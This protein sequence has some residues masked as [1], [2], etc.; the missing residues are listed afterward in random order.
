MAD[1]EAGLSEI[2]SGSDDD[3]DADDSVE[4]KPLQGEELLKS[5]EL[6]ED[7][8]GNDDAATKAK[9]KGADEKAD[10]AKGT[11]KG[12]VPAPE[13]AENDSKKPAKADDR[14]VPLK[15]LE[16]ERKKRQAEQKR[17]AELERKLAQL[18][19]RLSVFEKSNGNG[20]GKADETNPDDEFFAAGPSGFVE[21][22]LTAVEQRILQQVG[23]LRGQDRL[24][25]SREIVRSMHKDYD[26]TIATFREL[27]DGDPSLERQCLSAPNPAKW[28]YDYT[29][30]HQKLA[31]VGS[32]E[33]L[34]AQ[35]R[36]RVRQELEQEQRGN[37]ARA[38]AAKVSTSSAG[39]RSA[40]STAPVDVGEESL[41]DLL[42]D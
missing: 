30:L 6:R 29:K 40:G 25:M 12:A 31:N 35:I 8:P 13:S 3:S 21:K 33:D 32:L 36:E 4:T 14:H 18:E 41:E 26:E 11:K 24:A 27:A 20:Q 10:E 28:A 15:A 16:E 42:K 19:G 37:S 22:K 7:D 5:E 23:Q 17:S 38:E 2:I 34:E 39:A 9:A 1:V